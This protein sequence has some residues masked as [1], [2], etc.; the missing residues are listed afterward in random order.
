M[1]SWYTMT[2]SSLSSTHHGHIHITFPP[3]QNWTTHPLHLLQARHHSLPVLPV[4]LSRA[5]WNTTPSPGKLFPSPT[6]KRGRTA[7]LHSEFFG[8][9]HSPEHSATLRHHHHHH[10]ANHKHLHTVLRSRGDVNSSHHSR[11]SRLHKF[12]LRI[13]TIIVPF[14]HFFFLITVSSLFGIIDVSHSLIICYAH[15]FMFYLSS[16]SSLLGLPTISHCSL[17]SEIKI[18]NIAK[19]IVIM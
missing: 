17:L 12:T 14:R 8:R 19:P 4:R 6:V 10:V 2:P 18:A 3:F 9:C 13:L 5:P 15:T 1:I 11:P 7:P 16:Y